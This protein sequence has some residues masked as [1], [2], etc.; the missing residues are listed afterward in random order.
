MRFKYPELENRLTGKSPPLVIFVGSEDFLRREG[1]SRV[2]EHIHDG[3]PQEEDTTHIGT[4]SRAPGGE[5]LTAL[6]DELKTPSLFA[7]HRSIVIGNA[8]RFLSVD[9]EA[10]VKALQ[11]PWPQVTLILLLNSL[12]GRTKVAKAL[13][14]A[15]WIVTIERLFHRP[16]PWK[17]SASPWE[18]DLN[19]WIVARARREGL[20]ISP[21]TAHLLQ[22]RIGTSLGDLAASLERLGTVLK[23]QGKITRDLVEQHTPDGEESNLFELVDT[24]FMGD[25]R[26][27]LELARELL[28]RG[29]SEGNGSRTTD[30]ASLLLI[31]IGGALRRM[32]QL[33]EVHRTLEAGGSEADI[34]RNTGIARPFL[35][36]IH[37]QA[38]ATPPEVLDAVVK[39][40]RRA[41]RDLKTGRVSRADELLERLA[42]AGREPLR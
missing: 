7:P 29:S 2:L 31:F 20:S 33:R 36:R 23:G 9:T 6:F 15:G 34:L 4:E 10:W 32:R 18:N 12:D 38:K 30:P 8:E 1:V 35:P 14:K 22:S 24:F 37:M 19:R 26:R 39:Q 28:G 17:P 21:P 42:V 16:P 5:E 40:L 11:R 25:R 3:P 41:D 13:D 27:T